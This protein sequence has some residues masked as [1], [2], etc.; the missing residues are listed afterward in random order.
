VGADLQLILYGLLAM[1]SPLGF[2]A[3]LAVIESGRFKALGFGVGF[4]A[5]QLFACALLVVAGT[6]VVPNREAGHATFRA[7]LAIGFGVAVIVLAVRLRRRPQ[8]ETPKTSDRSQAVLERLGRL[9]VGTALVAGL[10]LGIGGPKRLVLTALA[11]ASISASA[12]D[13]SRVT[14]AV[15]AYTAVATLLA[16]A[17]ILAFEV[18]GARAVTRLGAAQQ[19]LSQHQRP[20]TYYSLLLIGVLAIADG[21][22]GLL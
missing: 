19:W 5:G 17:P 4:V 12:T 22:A 11:A 9:R 13:A 18:L 8:R 15:V 10:L 16:W 1:L 20:A 14:V 6:A 2:A 3:T 7:L 21:V